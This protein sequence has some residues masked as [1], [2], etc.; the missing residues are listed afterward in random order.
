MRYT[1]LQ[2]FL[3][4]EQELILEVKPFQKLDLSRDIQVDAGKV[5]YRIQ[6][7]TDM[8]R[9][10]QRLVI[11]IANRKKSNGS[12]HKPARWRVVGSPGAPELQKQSRKQ[13][14]GQEQQ[15]GAP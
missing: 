8:S 5:S 11:V 15:I 13:S 9:V 3:F 14:Q 12:K 6:R 10:G 7:A 1:V 2:V 4:E